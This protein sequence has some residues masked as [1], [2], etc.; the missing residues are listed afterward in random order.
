MC[1][2]VSNLSQAA[3][4]SKCCDD[5][6]RL[7][8]LFLEFSRVPRGGMIRNVKKGFKGEAENLKRSEPV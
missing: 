5:G 8:G 2:S 7:A 1:F 3:C 4:A 6:D